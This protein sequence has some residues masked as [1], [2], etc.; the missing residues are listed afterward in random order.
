MDVERDA[1]RGGTVN[2]G[3]LITLEGWLKE[4]LLYSHRFVMPGDGARAI[5]GRLGAGEIGIVVATTERSWALV[6]VI[7][8]RGELGWTSQRTLT[9][10]ART[11]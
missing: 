1:R 11:K 10:A 9:H 5:S 4:T 6:M 7:T 2:P 3:D 8:P